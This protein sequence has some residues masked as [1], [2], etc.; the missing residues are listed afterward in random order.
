M[1]EKNTSKEPGSFS[2]DLLKDALA[3]VQR[4]CKKPKLFQF[5]LPEDLPLREVAKVKCFLSV[6]SSQI[7]HGVWHGSIGGLGSPKTRR[8]L[9]W[10]RVCSFSLT[11]CYLHRKLLWWAKEPGPGLYP[12]PLAGLIF[13][14]KLRLGLAV[15]GC[16]FVCP[17]V[18][19]ASETL[20]GTLFFVPWKM[21]FNRH[22]YQIEQNKQ[23]FPH[24][25][26]KKK[27]NKLGKSCQQCAQM[28][29]G[30]IYIC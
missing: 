2:C 4:P 22:L 30:F 27:K 20:L 7:R 25:E 28:P 3:I 15:P 12:W 13:T 10:Y 23:N 8:C 18:S 6:L 9:C 26:K 14:G 29:L 5:L 17:A 24:N 1:Q 21:Q 16:G 19:M 11:F